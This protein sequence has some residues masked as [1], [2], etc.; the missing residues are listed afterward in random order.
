MKRL[1]GNSL[2]RKYKRIQGYLSDKCVLILMHF[3]AIVAQVFEVFMKP[4]ESK[5][6]TIHILYPECIGTDSFSS[7]KI[8]ERI[9]IWNR[10]KQKNYDVN[11]TNKPMCS[12]E[13]ISL[14]ID[15]ASNHKI[16]IYFS[17]N[18]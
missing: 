12:I 4:L 13:L 11:D 7:R 8:Y 17:S 5:E 6:P 14:K 15:N 1:K 10:V 2:N 9:M 16:L 3:V 18:I